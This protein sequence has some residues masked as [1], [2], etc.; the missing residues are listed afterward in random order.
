MMHRAV[1][2]MSDY[3]LPLTLPVIEDFR[4]IEDGNVFNTTDW[5]TAAWT[6]STPAPPSVFH[7]IFAPYGS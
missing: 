6:I 3:D 2:P 4:P 7:Y 1:G 5:Q